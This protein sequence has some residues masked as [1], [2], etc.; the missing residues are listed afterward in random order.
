MP[1]S[2]LVRP[3]DSSAAQAAG[4]SRGIGVYWVVQKSRG[5]P[6]RLWCWVVHV[7]D[8][9]WGVTSWQPVLGGKHGDIHEGVDLMWRALPR[10]VGSLTE[11][12]MAGRRNPNLQHHMSRRW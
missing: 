10:L 12:G 11:P 8:S 3:K 1:H 5:E 4:G 2:S 9:T 7:W 6:Q